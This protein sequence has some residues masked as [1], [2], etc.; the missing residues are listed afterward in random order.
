MSLPRAALD[1]F[2]DI[3][4]VQKRIAEQELYIKT[5]GDK[6]SPRYRKDKERV[7]LLV[8]S[9]RERLAFFK[10]IESFLLTHHLILEEFRRE[11]D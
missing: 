8:A 5:V 3:H 2:S 6:R 1:L 4:F 10:K 9:A 11:E 7:K